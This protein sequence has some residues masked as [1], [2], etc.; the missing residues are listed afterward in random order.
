VPGWVTTKIPGHRTQPVYR[1]YAAVSDEH[2]RRGKV[3]VAQ[4]GSIVGVSDRQKGR[5]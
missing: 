5:T 3:A 2:L 4:F 1:R